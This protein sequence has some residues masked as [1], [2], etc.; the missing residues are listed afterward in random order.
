MKHG[1]KGTKTIA[2]ALECF[3]MQMPERAEQCQKKSCP[4]NNNDPEYGCW[5]VSNSIMFDAVQ[6][7][8]YQ[9]QKIKRLE[10]QLDRVWTGRR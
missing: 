8:K 10:R 4:Y 9:E 7:L 1:R 3:R 5:C 6:R 2:D